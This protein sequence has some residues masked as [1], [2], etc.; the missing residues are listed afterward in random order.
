M[1]FAK[2]ILLL[3]TIIL[4][5]VS[6]EINAQTR[7]AILHSEYSLNNFN[8]D[9]NEYLNEYTAWEIFLMQ[10]K[11]N[12]K[13]I[14][15]KDLESGIED[16]FDILILPKYII[17]SKEVISALKKFMQS[18][19]SILLANTSVSPSMNNSINE[20]RDL[21]GITLTGQVV[22]NKINFTQTVFENPLNSYKN[23]SAFLISAKK[24]TQLVELMQSNCSAAGYILE[25]GK[26]NKVS[27]MVYGKS[28]SGKFVF[29]GFGLTDLI[30]G[31]KEI[32][33]YESFLLDALKWLDFEVDAFPIVTIEKKEKPRLLF[34]EHNNALNEN[35]I[36]VL[37]Q[38][39][40]NPHII[41][42]G[43]ANPAK[44]LLD[45]FLGGQVVVDIRE[46]ES[47]NSTIDEI[48]NQIKIFE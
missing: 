15:D 19:K 27:S 24:G 9:P 21:Y 7:I 28:N 33:E 40:L 6:I 12:F 48:I 5:A 35:F 46:L 38:N 11:I 41:I 3:F 44:I 13:V 34:I 16:E 22:N 10:N 1:S 4:S 2:K 37:N 25:I 42:S 32:L 20:L 18:R 14:Y 29:I 31:S 36:K 43:T 39:G 30:G 26:G 47:K 23:N 8:F 45:Q 17:H